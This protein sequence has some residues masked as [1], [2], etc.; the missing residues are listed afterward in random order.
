MS[1]LDESRKSVTIATLMQHSNLLSLGLWLLP[2]ASLTEVTLAAANEPFAIQ[3][4]DDDTGRGVPLVELRTVNKAAWWTDSNGIVAFDE[5]G[6]MELEVFFRVRSPGYEYPQ[7][8]FGNRGVKLKPRRGG[9]ATIQLKRLNIAQRLYRI[10]GAG[11]YR[12]SVLVGK[13][14]PLQ[15]PLLNAQVTG[16]DT[17]IATPYRGKIYWFWGDTDRAS[18][19]LGNFG[20]SGA[21]SELAGHGG[22]DPGL[23]V[24]LTYFVDEKEFSKAMCRLPGQ[25]AHWIQSLLALPDGKGGERLL[26]TVA[27]HKHLGE[28]ESWDLMLFNDEKAEFEPL[29]HWDLHE[30]HDSSHPFRAR[31]DGVDYFYLFPN[32]RVKADLESLRHLKNYEALTCVAGDG[33]IRGQQT[34]VDRDQ[35]SRPR[36]RWTPGADRLD[37]DRLRKLMEMGKL[38]PEESW[39]DLHDFET[40]TRVPAGRGSVYWNDFRQRWIMLNSSMHPGEIWF[41]ESDTPTGPWV[42]A[43]RVVTHGEYNFYNPTQH[44]FFDQDGG[45]LIYFEGTYSDFFSG[46]RTQTPRYDYNQ[47]MYRLSLDDPRLALPVAVY[48]VRGA[49]GLT[50]LWLRDQVE[51]AGAWERIEEIACF[52]LPP[53]SRGGDC[54]PV[55]A[56][57][58]NGTA[59]SLMPPASDAR[60]LFVGRPLA[61]SEPGTTL[62]GSWECRAVLA[63]GEEFKFSF[64]LSRQGEKVKLRGLGA[65]ATAAGTFRDGTLTLTLTLKDKDESF[66]MEGRFENRSLI[67]SW[68][69]EDGSEKGTWSALP[70]A[71]TPPEWRSPALVVLRKYRRSAEGLSDYSTQS[72]PPPGSEPGGRPLCRVWK[73]PGTVLTLDWK[74]HVVA[75]SSR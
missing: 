13:S 28:A 66:I 47:I 33:R 41:A 25:A 26:A 6:L 15:H 40:G 74:A 63:Q 12:D 19:P 45:R 30:G 42:Y 18:Y 17:V 65:D 72:Q 10:T 23:G 20:A 71:A 73:A 50:H 54:V 69:K 38:K 11:I 70:V 56:T 31:V 49:D 68:R 35:A 39:I 8:M 75:T 51:A 3:V 62:E 1:C 55:Y 59:L 43:R 5:P 22:L 34:D 64:V 37:P 2:L 4:V 36:Y 44:P 16:Q 29:E 14:A 60:P 21:T 58:K 27:N 48:R 9:S 46:A 32:W 61:E 7:D 53:T 52:A 57:E 24:D 67:G